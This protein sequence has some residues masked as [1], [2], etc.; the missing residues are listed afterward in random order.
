M[1]EPQP[2]APPAD[3]GGD[4]QFLVDPQNAGIPTS[5]GDMAAWQQR[6]IHA[7][8]TTLPADSPAREPL[9]QIA[10]GMRQ[11]Q[12]ASDVSQAREQA[13]R[14]LQPI[15][16]VPVADYGV[17]TNISNIKMFGIPLFQGTTADTIDVVTWLAKIINLAEN[18]T[19]TR[20]ATVRLMIQGSSG[21]AMS[22]INQMKQE[23]KT[24]H[25]VVQHLEMRYGDL[26]TPAEARIK[27]NSMV[28]KDK[29]GLSEFIDRMRLVARMACRL[30][31]TELA[32][33]LEVDKLVEANTRR[34]LPDSVRGHLEER[35]V[36]RSQVGLP[37]LSPRE[38]EKLCLELEKKREERRQEGQGQAKRHAI[39]KMQY[40]E[41]PQ[42][43]AFS[44]PSSE[45]EVDTD[46]EGTYGLVC[47]IKEQ[48]R[49]YAARGQNVAPQRIYRKA[50][51]KFNERAQRPR[52]VPR[53]GNPPDK[54]A[55]YG[56]AQYLGQVPRP[57]GQQGPPNRM[58]GNHQR[59]ILEL[60]ALANCSRGQCIQCGMEGHMMKRPECALKDRDLTDRPC[61]KCGKGLHAAD[62][63]LRV[64]QRQYGG[65]P[66]PPAG[67]AG[68]VQP[69]NEEGL[70]D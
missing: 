65:G 15:S 26:C 28:R 29:E 44:E 24:L 3:F 4:R 17:N 47:E 20:E 19:L 5:L 51:R 69:V 10:G 25:Q 18:H 68:A 45:D 1:G 33:M 12:L 36:N 52:F 8:L 63:C 7:M 35:I 30:E 57:M 42:E 6:F 23:H 2:G 34:V 54:R 38:I 49:K 11:V 32:R 53:G 27:C 31:P 55:P 22:Y 39:R 61:T 50:V 60:L 21:G 40:E 64:Y 66:Q 56:A 58:E 13:T 9:V 46:D 48:Q 67:P 16:D 59:T 14:E 37:A 70:N 62:E 43:I 41:V